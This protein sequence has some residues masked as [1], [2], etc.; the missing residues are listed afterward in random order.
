MAASSP[1][2]GDFL[3]R[4]DANHNGLLE[5]SELSDRVRPL[6]ER[7][8]RHA[9]L[10]PSR[11]ISIE[12]LRKGKNG[13][14]DRS[15]DD[16]DNDRDDRR[17]DDEND[18]AP[19]LVPGFGVSRELPA[20]PGF[21]TGEADEDDEKD[22][23][24][25]DNDRDRRRRDRDR[26]DDRRR[27]RDSDDDREERYRRYA[28]GLIRRYDENHNGR[29]EK[30]EWR[31]MR[32][33]PEKADKNG[34]GVITREEMIERL[35]DYSRRRSRG[36]DNDR[37]D[38]RSSSSS[39][40]RGESDNETP[41]HRFLTAVERLPEGLPDWFRDRDRDRDGQVMM[42][43]YASSWTPE[44]AR[45]FARHDLNRDG[46]VTPKEAL[47]EEEEEEAEE[48]SSQSRDEERRE[49]DRRGWR[50]W[51]RR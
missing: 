15:R 23:R 49:D 48:E 19:P 46:V 38:S 37:D 4:L 27:S 40:S 13:D 42:H 44:R 29:L 3:D 18:D 12:K 34:D 43:E 28:E 47:P 10:D 16:E 5:A 25:D 41:P 51:R 45:E 17:R 30:D 31:G 22:R 6:I 20:V 21:G 1:A 11:P 50:S 39:E 8:A 24:R 9:G 26:D 32:G 36:D 35:L 33:E 7:A 2:R 14:S